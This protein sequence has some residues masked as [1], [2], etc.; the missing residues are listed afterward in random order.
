[1]NKGDI[2]TA[3]RSDNFWLNLYELN[4]QLQHP[5]IAK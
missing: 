1:M 3:E 4:I 5:I 2:D